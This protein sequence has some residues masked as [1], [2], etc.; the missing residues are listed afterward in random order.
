MDSV[1]VCQFGELL[2]GY[3]VCG[4][5]G[6]LG[7][8]ISNLYFIVGLFLLVVLMVDIV[9][10]VYIIELIGYGVNGVIGDYSCGVFGF[11]I[12]NGEIIYL[13]SEVIIVGYL[14]EIFKL[15][16]LVNNFEFCYGVNVLIV[17]I[18]GLMFG[19]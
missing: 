16:Q 13:V 9:D 3:V 11:W 4:G 18:E 10:G 8:L 1:L 5:G 17:C 15:M 19:G 7:V 6:V 12:E 14:F 2:I